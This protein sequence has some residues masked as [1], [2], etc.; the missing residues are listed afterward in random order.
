RRV[1]ASLLGRRPQDTPAILERE[2][3]GVVDEIGAFRVLVAH[4]S[5]IA[6]VE[7]DAAAR[8]RALRDDHGSD[9]SLMRGGDDLADPIGREPR[10]E[11]LMEAFDQVSS[12]PL[13]D[14][15]D[16]WPGALSELIVREE[17]RAG[18]DI[19]IDEVRVLIERAER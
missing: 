4:E 10:A 15:C 5:S 8:R 16:R 3:D 13:E 2:D 12:L 18:D 1:D 7:I 9:P 19:V 6:R 14:R 11:A 17:V